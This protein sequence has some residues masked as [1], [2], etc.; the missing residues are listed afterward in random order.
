MGYVIQNG[1][2]FPHMTVERNC[3]LL[4]QLE[5]WSRGRVRSRVREL[6]Q[7]VNLDPDEFGHRPPHELSGGQRQRVGVARALAL[8]PPIVL[9]D[10]PFGALDPITR[11]QLHGEFEQLKATVRKTVLFVTHDMPEAFKLGDRIAI[12]DKGRLVQ[13]GTESDFRDRPT[14]AFVEDFVRAHFEGTESG[15]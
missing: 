10:E 15:G 1:G 8:D 14:S 6:L 4:C 3:G 2:L 12:L 7:L 5:G 9:M 13:V 11:S